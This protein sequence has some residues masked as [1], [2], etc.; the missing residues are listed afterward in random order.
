MEAAEAII[1]ISVAH[2]IRAV[3]KVSVER[4]LDPRE[5]TLVPFGG[6]GPLHAGLLLRHLQLRG[7]LVPRRPGLFSATGC[8]PPGCGSTTPRPC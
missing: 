4:G 1:A 3:R 2:M 5:F 7:V 8:S 6:A